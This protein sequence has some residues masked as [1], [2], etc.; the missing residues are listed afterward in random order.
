MFGNLQFA[1]FILQFAFSSTPG[2]R[3]PH[4]ETQAYGCCVS[5]LTR[6]ARPPLQGPLAR[7]RLI[8]LCTLSRADRQ[9]PA[10]PRDCNPVALQ[11][12]GFVQK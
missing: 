1:L 10:K 11:P 4:K 5:T 8:H 2:E 12:R 7:G 9:R 6:F 3:P